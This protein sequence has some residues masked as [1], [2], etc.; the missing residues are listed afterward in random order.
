MRAGLAFVLVSL[1]A[2]AAF[3]GWQREHETRFADLVSS[4]E[5]RSRDPAS[6][7]GERPAPG[8][9]RVVSPSSVRTAPPLAPALVDLDRAGA[10]EL[11]RLPGIGPALAARIVADREARG[12]FVI[13]E[14]LLRVNGI[15]PRTLAR[16]RTYL[17]APAAADSQS[18]IAK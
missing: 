4:L 8:D 5:R 3:R 11:E 14:S 6:A 2:G 10:A 15:G 18:P 1:A 9:A 13:P 12:P 7:P 17:A 16:I